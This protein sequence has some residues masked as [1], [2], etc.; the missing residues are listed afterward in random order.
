MVDPMK[1]FLSGIV[2]FGAVLICL[3]PFAWMFLS[4]FKT[5]RE[6]YQPTLFIPKDFEPDSYLS[7]FSD[8]YIPFLSYFL[9][10]TF[11]SVCQALLAVFVTAAAGF[12]FAKYSFR[13][14]SIVFGIAILVILIPKQALAV[15]LFDWMLWLGLHGGKWAL[16]LPGIAS[17]L[18]I[19]FFTQVFR[20]VPD[21]LL[22]LA[23]VEGLSVHRT[24]LLILPLAGPALVTYGLLHFILSWQEHLLPLLLLDDEN[25]TLPIALAK[26]RD[27]SHRI[28]EAVGMAAATMSLLPVVVLFGICFRKM[29]T[30]LVHLA[31]S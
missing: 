18:G 24:F 29:K 14:K 26:L 25:I 28:P 2:L 1:K 10:S 7:L 6:I 8:Q 30:A 31:L 19:V 9:N 16:T 5:N 12:V 22:E 11:I 3:Y 17:G 20:K 27:S 15:P 21:E 23:K 4:S 13:G